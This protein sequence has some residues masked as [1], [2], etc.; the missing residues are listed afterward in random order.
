MLRW[1]DRI[2]RCL[3]LNWLWRCFWKALGSIF[4]DFLPL[5]GMAEGA[6]NIE[7]QIVFYDFCYFGCWAVGLNFWSIFN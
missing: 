4:V 7:K 1:H 2:L 6:K 5:H 3:N